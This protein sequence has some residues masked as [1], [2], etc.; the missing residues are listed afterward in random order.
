VSVAALRQNIAR[1][2]KNAPT[3]YRT[4][5]IGKYINGY[6]PADEFGEVKDGPA[7][8]G[9]DYW[10]G[11]GKDAYVGVDYWAWDDYAVDGP[12]LVQYT[13]NDPL[14][15]LTDV[16]GIKAIEFLDV[17]STDPFFLVITPMA[18]HTPANPAFRHQSLYPNE[19]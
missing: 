2:L 5:I 1:W 8:I 15:Y 18:P 10:F 3:P 14:N 12:G 6:R 17:E 4:G 9:F 13:G 19:L 11:V 7:E 16:L